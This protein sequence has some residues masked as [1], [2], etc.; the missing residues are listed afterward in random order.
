ME[1]ERVR[2]GWDDIRDFI[3]VHYK[4]NH[5]FDTPF[6]KQCRNDMS[7]GGATEFCEYYKHAGPSTLS[8]RLITSD[9][10]FG[11]EGY[12]NV[13]LGLK[14]ET[15]RPPELS[16]EDWKGW[17]RHSAQVSHNAQQALTTEQA[18]EMIA[19]EVQSSLTQ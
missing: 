7:L 19:G 12:M 13:L 3:V 17:E 6:W 8:K 15:D 14:A 5:H 1:C 2:S 9:S 11:F 16:A 18:I 10:V 4:F